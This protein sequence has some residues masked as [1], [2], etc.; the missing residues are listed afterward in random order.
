MYSFNTP[1]TEGKEK[2][3]REIVPVS[4]WADARRPRLPSLRTN[5]GGFLDGFRTYPL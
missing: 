3:I 5:C 1:S 4:A 2:L